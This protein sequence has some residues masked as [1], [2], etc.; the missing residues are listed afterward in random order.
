MR[1]STRLRTRLV[2]MALVIV[3]PVLAFLLYNQS[4]ERA[5]SRRD[6]IEDTL[7]L[8]HL[9]ASEEGT[10]LGGVQRF[11]LTLAEFPGLRDNSPAGCADLL[12]HLFRAH[13]NYINIWVVNA[14]GSLFC[15]ARPVAI[16]TPAI[17]ERAWFQRALSSRTT[18]VGDY[19]I[20]AT[21][22]NPDVV[23]AHPLIDE[24]GRVVR[25]LGVGISLEQLSQIAA[26]ARIP[27]GATL[28]LTDQRHTVLARFPED[29]SVIGK[30]QSDRMAGLPKSDGTADVAE[31]SGVDG[32]RRLYAHVP[33]EAELNTGLTV[34]IAVEPSAI[35]A[36][37][38]FLLRRHLWLLLLVGLVAVGVALISGQLFIV[39]PVAALG[40]L[41]NRIATGDHEARAELTAGLTGLGDLGGAV[42]TLAVALDTHQRTLR[43]SE[44]RFRQIAETITEVFW[45]AD[46]QS[47][48]MLYLSPAYERIWGR[49]CESLYKNP[50][51]FV[52]AV[53]PDD[54]DDVIEAMK[55]QE[56][57]EPFDYE[58]RIVRPDGDVRWIWDRGFPVPHPSGPPLRYVGVA[59]DVTV[60]K[61]TDEHIQLLARA[62]ES[63]NEMVSVTDLN[64]RFTFVNK[65]FLRTYGYRAEE[66][67]GRT[68]AILQPPDLIRESA[69]EILRETRRGGWQGEIRNRRKDGSELI[70]SLNTSVIQDHHGRVIGLLG[71]ARDITERLKSERAIREAEERTRFALEASHV[72]IWE[73]DL[74]HDVS[75]WSETC[76]AMHGLAPGTFGKTY[77]S[78]M[79]CIHPDDRQVVAGAIQQASKDRPDTKIEYRSVWPD[80]ALHQISTTAHFVFDPDGTPARGVGFVIDVSE[81]RSLEDQL[82]HAQKMEAVGQLAGGIA[83]DFNNML[84]AILGNAELAMEE[85]AP[86]GPHRTEF[87]EIV[88]AGN[89]AAALTRQLLAFSRKQVLAPRVLHIGQIV[90]GV[91]PMLQRLIGESIELRI[92]LGDRG[93]VKADAGQV[94]QVLMNLA[95]NARDAMKAGGYLTIETN[96]VTLDEAYARLHPTVHAGH[97]VMIAVSDTGHG[98]DAETQKHV[99]EPFFTTKPKG[100]GTGLGLATVYGIVKQSGGH[101]W[102]YSEIGKGTTFKVY[103]PRTAEAVTVASPTPSA[104]GHLLG[105]ETILYVEDEASVREFVHKVLSRHGYNVHAMGDAAHALEFARAHRDPI[106]LVFTDVV[107]PGMSGPAMAL[108]LRQEHPESKVL[109]ASGYTDNAIVHHGVLDSRV[110]FLQKPFTAEALVMRVRNVLDQA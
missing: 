53:H 66:V 36:E 46:V 17:R 52:D 72:G 74:K 110:A 107:L 24:S 59:E 56:A 10:L 78:F 79:N 54:V 20:S 4:I 5:R 80:G 45:M 96:D 15:E 93:Q 11:L 83:H 67:L 7:R 39:R 102:L 64:D 97:Y 13:P 40:A 28:T 100:E 26:R 31:G 9:V 95:V 43:E 30:P 90:S 63:T 12:P 34:T 1:P 33:I 55:K 105:H 94:E 16:A 99:F 86:G 29:K 81:Q 21:T 75:F 92:V 27:P 57:G 35:F 23:I 69:L 109:Y 89:R 73:A 68:P 18:V 87:E 48:R 103:L 70:V 108:E 84:T 19:Q 3:V 101:I 82:R 47:A 37:S 77:Q 38:D 71:V 98:I 65:A 2:M 6:A 44:Q 104:R 49:S 61:E 50:K 8:A 76:E 42:E 88:N 32:R 91:T 14:D 62:I 60:R 41:T 58:Y 25:I 51:S 22:Q 106:D 85:I